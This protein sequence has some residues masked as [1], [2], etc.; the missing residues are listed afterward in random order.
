M[1]GAE[2]PEYTVKTTELSN[3]PGEK[4]EKD[5]VFILWI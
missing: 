3:K 2:F 5:R 1:R 4:D